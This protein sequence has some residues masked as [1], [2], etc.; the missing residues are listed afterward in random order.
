MGA[1]CSHLKPLL[2]SILSRFHSQGCWFSRFELDI[3]GHRVFLCWR[4][5]CTIIVP[6]NWLNQVTANLA[7]YLE[8]ASYFPH[9]SGAEVAY[10]EKV[11]FPR[12]ISNTALKAFRLIPV[13]DSSCQ[14]SSLS[15][16]SYCPSAAVT[17][18][19]SRPSYSLLL[20]NR[21]LIFSAVLAKYLLVAG[22]AETSTWNVR[23][24]AVGAFTVIIASEHPLEFIKR[25]S[26][27]QGSNRG[28]YPMGAQAIK[29]SWCRQ[30]SDAHLVRINLAGR[31]A[32][33]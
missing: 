33:H 20:P 25:N 9:R 32:S 4:F 17:P 12:L 7:V 5:I 13:R 1:S 23:G 28:Q 29:R 22:G 27:T 19:V 16:P 8:Y 31:P 10:L 21:G 30:S 26:H 2:I 14:L 11:L 15:S 24:L 6:S 18:L 3:L